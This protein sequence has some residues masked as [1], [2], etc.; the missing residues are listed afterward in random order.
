MAYSTLFRRTPQRRY[1]DY[2]RYVGASPA[3]AKE[4]RVWHLGDFLCQRY[5]S[6]IEEIDRE[7]AYLARKR[8]I[9][10]SLLNLCSLAGHYGAYAIVLLTALAGRLSI[11]T[12]TFLASAFSRSRQSM[13]RILSN[14]NDITEEALYLSDVFAFFDTIPIMKTPVDPILAPMPIRQG[15]EFQ[16]V[17]FRYP[18]SDRFVLRDVSFCLGVNETLALVGENGA[19]KSTLVKLMTRLYDP[20][21]GRILL[22]GSDLRDYSP[23]DIRRYFGVLFQ[24]FVRYDMSVLDN[25]GLGDTTVR[26]N[27][28][29]VSAA[30]TRA[31]LKKIVDRFPHGFE[32]ILGQRFEGGM[33][34]SG[35]EWQR[36]ALARALFRDAQ[37]LILD[38][39]AA[40]LDARAEA[41]LIRELGAVRCEKMTVMITHRLSTARWADKII[42]LDAGRVVESGEH[43]ELMKA[44]GR[45][46]ELFEL[47]ACGY[48]DLT[49]AVS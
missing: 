26:H 44:G 9:L 2:I 34:L 17:S 30:A 43:E 40:N 18:G 39:P 47:Q 23:V 35:G 37:V 46:A 12:F 22:D 42:V 32:Q 31:G 19:G 6:A 20:T 13:E 7:N 21:E 49:H 11:G 41:D 28:G 48:R 14:V 5:A 33:D 38:E 45:Y 4:V 25:I 27:S 3:T 1:L 15:F 8:T 16:N 36:V 10:G 24:D 29:K